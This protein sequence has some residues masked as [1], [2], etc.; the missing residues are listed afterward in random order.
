M[1]ENKPD[2]KAVVAVLRRLIRLAE[3]RRAHEAWAKQETARAKL[4]KAA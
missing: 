1:P 2:R 3:A 4:E